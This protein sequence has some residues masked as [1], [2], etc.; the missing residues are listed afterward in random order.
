MEAFIRLPCEHID[1]NNVNPIDEHRDISLAKSNRMNNGAINSSPKE[2]IFNV[3]KGSNNDNRDVSTRYGNHIEGNRDIFL[4]KPHTMNNEVT[5]CNPKE[6]ILNSKIGPSD[7]NMTDSHYKRPS[8][9]E[10]QKNN[11]IVGMSIFDANLTHLLRQ[12]SSS[13]IP[14]NNNKKRFNKIQL[15]QQEE[16]FL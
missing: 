13:F 12:I 6:D 5:H 4:A 7:I 8:E 14:N 9:K 1:N 2:D 15:L 11:V 10:V 16:K 3:T